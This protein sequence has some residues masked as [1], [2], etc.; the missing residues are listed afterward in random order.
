MSTISW[1]LSPPLGLKDKALLKGFITG[2]FARGTSL[3]GLEKCNYPVLMRTRTDFEIK[4][5]EVPRGN[6][7]V[8][9]TLEGSGEIITEHGHKPLLMLLYL[10][11]RFREEFPAHK[12]GVLSFCTA[13]GKQFDYG[14]FSDLIRFGFEPREL[15]ADTERLGLVSERIQPIRLAEIDAEIPNF[16]F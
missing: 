4:F 7:I 13:D 3:I 12:R 9:N 5:S 16:Y 1:V 8:P 6:M 10:E 11:R 15:R 14:Q 2:V